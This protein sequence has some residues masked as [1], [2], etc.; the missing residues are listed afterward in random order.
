MIGCGLWCR[1]KKRVFQAFK[2]LHYSCF[3]HLFTRYIM[4]VLP[5]I[6]FVRF[7][8][9]STSGPQ[10]SSSKVI[11]N[12]C[13]N[14]GFSRLLTMDICLSIA[15][16]RHFPV[17]YSKLQSTSYHRQKFIETASTGQEASHHCSFPIWQPTRIQNGFHNYFGIV[18]EETSKE[19]QASPKC[20]SS[21]R[22]L[23]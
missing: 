17:T 14:A 2:A 13:H 4:A 10:A 20:N 7:L 22:L 3:E 8:Q 21:G 15:Q 23:S 5:A 12:F 9:S 1:R 19:S 11:H 18:G 16:K 6:V